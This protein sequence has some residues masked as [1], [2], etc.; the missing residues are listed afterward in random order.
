MKLFQPFWMLRET[1]NSSE[2]NSPGVLLSTDS[3]GEGCLDCQLTNGTLT[4][5]GDD[6]QESYY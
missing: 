6:I 2:P 3:V 1:S 4:I 5:K